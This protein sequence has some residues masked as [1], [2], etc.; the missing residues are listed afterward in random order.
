MK[1]IPSHQ[2]HPPETAAKK[3]Q[4]M[5]QV[6]L[7]LNTLKNKQKASLEEGKYA[8]IAYVRIVRECGRQPSII[9]TEFFSWAHYYLAFRF[10][11]LY[12]SV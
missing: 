5:Y 9:L 3:G 4:V 10:M 7:T 12:C 6:L 1:A 2:K 8:L 11:F